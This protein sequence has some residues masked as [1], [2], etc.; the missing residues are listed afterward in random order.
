MA[1]DSGSDLDV[2]IWDDRQ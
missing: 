1:A 2:N